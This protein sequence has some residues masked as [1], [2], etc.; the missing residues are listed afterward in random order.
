MP[1]SDEVEQMLSSLSMK[2]RDD[3]FSEIPAKFRKSVIRLPRSK[4]EF[5]VI[6]A[7]R[8][9]ARNNQWS[10]YR[11]F[12]GMGFYDRI[13]PASVDSVI[14]R[15]EFLTSYTPYQ[16][17]VSQGML[18]SLFEY[19][20]I[21]SDLMHMDFSN[22]SMYDGYSA[23]GEAVRMAFR[24]NG[25]PRVLIPENI[26]DT[27]LRVLESYT[28]GLNIKFERYRVSP[29]T[30]ETDL[31][32]LKGLVDENISAII[33]ENPNSYGVLDR[34]VTKVSEIKKDALLIAYVDPISLGLVK[35]PG[36]YGADIAVAEGQQMG[37]HMNYGG[38]YLGIFTFR[39]DLVRKSPGR[40]IG[41]T[42]D[43]NGKR[44]FVMTLQTRE[45][46]IRREKA[47]SNI[48]T[49]QAL[50]ALASLTYLSLLGSAGLKKVAAVT[51]EK[52]R[53]FT[54]N[55]KRVLSRDAVP[56]SGV[57]FSDV[58]VKLNRNE[59]EL[60]AAL[61]KNRII[62]GIPLSRVIPFLSDQLKGHYAFSFTEKTADSD[63]DL[64]AATLG[65][66]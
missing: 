43:A 58:I 59:K 60:S 61:I 3:L 1:R 10:Q 29:I 51:M 23:L 44:A 50:M 37:I 24:E 41:E 33:V 25:R 48:C 22:S 42:V 56:F 40:I 28:E 15:S 12:L 55:V 65:G 16:P 21:I 47:T 7:A 2:S 18:Q 66:M 54:E 31:E 64:L 30:G 14:S 38:P 62:G 26:I 36:D 6:E 27:K 20:S 11:N 8:S 63:I 19:Q 46:H 4:S 39:K 5:E 9:V 49:N 13:I 45:Q 34:N 17:E 35:P 52:S 32:N 57:H 53:K